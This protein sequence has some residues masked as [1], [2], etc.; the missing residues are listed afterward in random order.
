MCSQNF[1]SYLSTAVMVYNLVVNHSQLSR[2]P[3][4]TCVPVI[5]QILICYLML[6]TFLSRRRQVLLLCG[7][8]SDTHTFNLWLGR[9]RAR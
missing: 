6:L 9:C 4:R 7:V 3:N 5:N 2:Q 8:D 1:V